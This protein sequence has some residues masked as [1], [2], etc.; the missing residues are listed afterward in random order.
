M[1]LFLPSQ[2]LNSILHR[3]D[4]VSNFYFGAIIELSFM[5]LFFSSISD[6][7]SYLWTF[8]FRM[9]HK[10]SIGFISGLFPGYSKGFIFLILMAK[11]FLVDRSYDFRNIQHNFQLSWSTLQLLYVQCLEQKNS[12]KS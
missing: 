12:P 6:F 3:F 2:R 10:F 7:G 5:N 9:T 1:C 4:K 11:L 8:D